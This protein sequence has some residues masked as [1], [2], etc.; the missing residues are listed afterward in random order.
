VTPGIEGR[1]TLLTMLG[2]GLLVEALEWSGPPNPLSGALALRTPWCYLVEG[3]AVRGR[4]EGVT[5]SGNLFELLGRLVA[6]GSDAR[7]VGAVSVPSLVVEGL[8]V[9]QT[10]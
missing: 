6:V 10:A 9:A 1:A 8:R 4:L 2:R 5:L 7:W 3:G